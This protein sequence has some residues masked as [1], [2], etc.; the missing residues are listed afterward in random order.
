L[1][2]LLLRGAL[3]ASRVFQ[4]GE[5]PGATDQTHDHCPLPNSPLYVGLVQN[6][7]GL[8]HDAHMALLCVH[9]SSACIILHVNRL[10][11]DNTVAAVMYTRYWVSLFPLSNTPS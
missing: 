9:Y 6:C 1:R 2:R 11:A 8:Q 3:V 10:P 7:S 5:K 4:P